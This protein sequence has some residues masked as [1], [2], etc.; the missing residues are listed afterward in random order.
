MGTHMKT[1]IE[2]PDPLLRE[3]KKLA[4]RQ[5]RTLRQLVEVALRQVIREEQKNPGAFS[6]RDASVGGRGLREGLR[7]DDWARILE[8]A[9]E[10]RG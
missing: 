1:T 10:E 2:I 4:R 3:A 9:Y 7:Y 5:G 6:L 8:L